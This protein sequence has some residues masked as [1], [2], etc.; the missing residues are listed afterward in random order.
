MTLH[1]YR[2]P[3]EARNFFAPDSEPV[4]DAQLPVVDIQGMSDYWRPHPRL[5]QLD[6]LTALKAVP[7]NGSSPDGN[8]NYF[9]DDFRNAYVPGT[10]LTGTGQ[11]VGLLEFDGFYANDIAA[12]AQAAG[13][14]RANIVIQ[15]VLLDSYNGVPTT[16][17]NSGNGEVSLDIELAMAL[18]LRSG[19]NRS[20]RGGTKRVAK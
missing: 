1:T 10:P 6:A 4:V 14:G 19:E 7:R 12:Y 20:L 16:G 8:A 13:S 17:K 3:T 15:T 11:S 18:A 9:G 2:H 5:R